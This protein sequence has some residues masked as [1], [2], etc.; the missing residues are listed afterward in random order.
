MTEFANLRINKAVVR[1]L[2]LVIRHWPL[3]R[4]HALHTSHYALRTTFYVLPTFLLLACTATPSPL[5][6]H[7][8]SLTLTAPRV[9][10]ADQPVQ[11]AITAPDAS[12]GT[13]VTL[14]AV[15]SYGAIPFS[16][17]LTAGEVT[18]TLPPEFTRAAGLVTLS[19]A[20]G[21]AVARAELTLRPSPA[22]GQLPLMVGPRSIAANG[23]D[24]TMAVALP[25]DSY[26][27][28]L[29]D[30]VPVTF[31]VRHPARDIEKTG[32]RQIITTTIQGGV[33]WAQPRSGTVAGDT[34]L[35]AYS[36][37]SHSTALTF[38]E[39]AGRPLP[40]TLHAERDNLPADGRQLALLTTSSL[41]DVFG[42]PL[43]DG[44]A[45]A[46]LVTTADGSRRSIPA[47]TLNG[48][49]QG[50][51]QAPLHPGE[52]TVQ[53][54]LAG[55]LSDP[56]TLTFVAG[57]VVTDF[58]VTL[59]RFPDTL[60]I[61][62]GPLVGPLGQ[63]VPDG[64]PVEFTLSGPDDVQSFN[65][66]AEFGHAV[67]TLRRANLLTGTYTVTVSAGAGQGRASFDGP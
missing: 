44:L 22:A 38:A 60:D 11:V 18:F 67:L 61:S 16:K 15:G 40:F 32:R 63:F 49:A 3:V 41:A 52:L 8:S 56:L 58:P 1:R 46:F 66:P 57:P 30:G 21:E 26:G 53:A 23:R 64:T 48:R 59:W 34:T 31:V 33:A 62:A 10:T 13:L 43:P 12:D 20:A 14:T 45:V 42:N 25:Q 51:V 39:T 36:G 6:L 5:I 4:G 55:V 7:P 2:L 27:N 17:P 35:A 29:P 9:A 24:K 19:A 28:P 37:D 65:A 50:Q 47:V 54:D